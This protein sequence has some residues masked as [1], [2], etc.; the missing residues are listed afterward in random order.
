VH[1]GAQSP[2]RGHGP[3]VPESRPYPLF[4]NA[5]NPGP[6][7]RAVWVSAVGQRA[8]RSRT[9]PQLHNALSERTVVACPAIV[10]PAW[11]VASLECGDARLHTVPVRLP[12][13]LR[14]SFTL[15]TR[16]SRSKNKKI[17]RFRKIAISK[18]RHFRIYFLHSCPFQKW[19]LVFLLEVHEDACRL[20]TFLHTKKKSPQAARDAYVAATATYTKSLYE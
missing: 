9:D 5:P 11:A 17:T 8:Q 10:T 3:G 7:A 4:Q 1:A 13:E 2:L 12:R 18:N 15:M 14:E 16:F 19:S 20:T 6:P